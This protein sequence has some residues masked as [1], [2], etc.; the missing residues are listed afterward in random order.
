M[1]VLPPSPKSIDL[2]IALLKR[3]GIVAH[4]T[5]TCYGLACDLTSRAAV[6]RLFLMKNRP[7]LQPVSALFPSIEEA[8]RYVVWSDHAEELAKKHL[9]GP[10]TIILP[11]RPDAP[12]TLH[13]TP[14]KLSTTIG[15][16]ISS[17]PIAQELV[18]R[19]GKPLSTTS[20]NIHG[21]PPIYS[22]EAVAAQFPDTVSDIL[23][24]DGGPLPKNPP[25]T[26]IDLTP[27]LPQ[28]VRRGGILL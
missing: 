13:C 16:R 17:N 24:L 26:I 18:E 7:P 4:P 11:L 23:L 27:P 28:E 1:Q 12:H 8:K 22:P 9:P 5:E 19:F 15:I 2:A 6:S 10:L 25:S 21:N 14:R 20:A 3:R